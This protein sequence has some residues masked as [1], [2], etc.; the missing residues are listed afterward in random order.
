MISRFSQNGNDKGEQ[1]MSTYKELGTRFIILV[2]LIV[3][4]IAL[5]KPQQA[6][7]TTCLQQCAIDYQAC[8]AVC[9]SDPLGPPEGCYS[10]CL[11][12]Y[13]SCRAGC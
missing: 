9:N 2:V 6:F 12:S 4:V 7:A 3:A 1:T 5:A 11:D 13:V 10:D 8:L